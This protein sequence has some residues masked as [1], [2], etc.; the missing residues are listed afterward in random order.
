M[1]TVKK[2]WMDGKM[3][4]WEDCQVHVLTHALH[5]G[6]AV[7]EGIR[8]YD[9]VEGPAVFLLKEHIKR[10]FQSAKAIAMDIP[11]TEKEL[12]DAVIDTIKVNKIK[13]GY[14]RPIAFYGYGKM[15]LNPVGAPVQVVIAIWPWGAYLGEDTIKV[16]TSTY[17]RLHPKSLNTE[18]KVAGHYVNSIMASLEAKKAGC[19]EALLLDYKG[20]VAEGPG[21]NIF[22]VKKGKVYTPVL[23]NILAG[24]TRKSV[25]QMAKDLG[26]TVVEKHLSI[27]DVRKA[28]E[29]FFTG[30]AAEVT[31]I[32]HLDG[33]PINKGKMGP[34]T[35]KLRTLFHQVVQ[36][37]VSKYKKWLTVVK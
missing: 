7:F 13:A 2:I 32:G 36:G 29:A 1:E 24:L 34:V 3:K 15:G 16:K 30:T 11:F 37:K 22:V 4:N 9:T 21:E 17:I 10:L 8:F 19:H 28:D 31:A 27:N 12:C 26:F 6:S 14:I 25:M 23:G 35:E 33:K 18:A 5:Y 20:K